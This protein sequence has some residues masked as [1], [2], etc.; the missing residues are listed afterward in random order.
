[1]NRTPETLWS[2]AWDSP[3]AVA[4]TRRAVEAGYAKGMLNPAQYALALA[5]VRAAE[6]R[7]AE[8]N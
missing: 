7:N 6:R 5:N 2:I 8:K 3:A 4:D 1:M